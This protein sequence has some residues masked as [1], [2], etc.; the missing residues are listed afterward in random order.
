M[1]GSKNGK[2]QNSRIRGNLEDK[3]ISFNFLTKLH[4]STDETRDRKDRGITTNTGRAV[5]DLT[6]HG[7]GG[8][9]PRLTLAPDVETLVDA[10]ERGVE[11]T[12]FRLDKERDIGET[13]RE[14]SGSSRILSILRRLILLRSNCA[15]RWG[16]LFDGTR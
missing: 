2:F 4:G 13:D 5:N 12:R 3:E 6:V 14:N 7:G 1:R 16:N 10:L 8:G 11:M 15:T 9:S